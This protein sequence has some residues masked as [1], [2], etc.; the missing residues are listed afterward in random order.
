MNSFQFPKISLPENEQERLLKLHAYDILDTPSENTFD[1]I[2]ILAAQIFNTPIAQVTF[3][4]QDRVFFKTNISPLKATEIDRKD[5]FCSVAILKEEVTLIEN[6]LDVP[7]L[8]NNPFVTME[9]GVRFYAGAPLKTSE[10]HQLG[11][12][13]VIDT[14]P[15]EV[16]VDQIKM[17]ETLSS[18]VMD[19]LELRLASRKAIRV[20]NDMMNRIVHD[21]KNPNT[22]IAL[23][24]ELIKRKSTDS[25][26]V[27]DFAERISQSANRV[28]SSLNNLLDIS[29]VESGNLELK[30][31]EVKIS[32]LLQIVKKNFDLSASKKDQAIIINCN[33]ETLILI[34][35]ARMQ[36]AF[37]N[38]LSNAIKYSESGTSIHINVSSKENGLTIEFKDQ[39]QGLTEED[40]AK[41]FMKFAKLS[42]IPT[43][44]EHSN[45]LGLSI[46]KMLVELH[47]GKVWAFS[48]GKDKG[49]S[50]FIF[51]PNTR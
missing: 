35:V 37:E 41:L 29:Q 25:K 45:G 34:D 48:D 7:E 23:S 6:M 15:R 26:T 30:L 11:T 4:D 50:F 19:E 13:C 49:T 18:I 38:L 36:E 28:L 1:K 17:L 33:C 20:Q 42:A 8:I 22:T 24:A 21:L 27:L 51:I 5:S 32:D 14:Q 47:Q 44:K 31:E 2:A 9:N 40:M 3:V 16:T 39:G 12:L 10:G 46:V 43:G